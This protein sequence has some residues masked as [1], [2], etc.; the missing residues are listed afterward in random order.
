[1]LNFRNINFDS[2]RTYNIKINSSDV[3]EI[4]K[5][6]GWKEK[7]KNGYF[8]KIGEPNL[9]LEYKEPVWSISYCILEDDLDFYIESK[10]KYLLI[11]AETGEVKAGLSPMTNWRTKWSSN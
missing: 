3:I 9:K 11:H 4:A 1:M 7:S 8:S 2:E 6:H 10:C 5:A